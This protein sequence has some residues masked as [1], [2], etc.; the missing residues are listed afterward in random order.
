MAYKL[1]TVDTDG[2]E[3]H[4][5]GLAVFTVE[6][7]SEPKIKNPD[8]GPYHEVD[9]RSDKGRLKMFVSAKYTINTKIGRKSALYE[10]AE[11]CFN[12]APDEFE[13]EA[14]TGRTFMGLV[15]HILKDGQARDKIVN[16]LP[17]P[18]NPNS[19]TGGHD[20]FAGGKNG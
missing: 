15:D 11:A 18:A 19:P 20:P 9:V 13:I 10:L 14:L 7:V 3:I 2:F 5:K 17:A 1:K 16:V 12:G 6:A 4:P 8:Y